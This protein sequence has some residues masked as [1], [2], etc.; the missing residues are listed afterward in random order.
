[1]VSVEDF[2]HLVS[3]VYTAAAAPDYWEQ[4]LHDVHQCLGGISA[5]L[6]SPSGPVWSIENSNLP[7]DAVQS[8]AEHYCHLDHVLDAVQLGP[9]GV[10]RTGS[11]LINPFRDTEFYSEWMQPNFMEDGLFVRLADGEQPTCFVVATGLRSES[12]ATPDRVRMVAAL[13]PHLQQ[14]IR[15]RHKL[16]EL[17]ETTA[18]L[19]GALEIVRHGVLIVTADRRVLTLNSAAERILR[20]ADGLTL[21]RG[22]IT[23]AGS[24]AAAELRSAVSQAV[25]EDADGVRSAHSFIC[26]R[27]SGKRPYVVHVL[28]SHRPDAE[29][30]RH[31]TALLLVIDPED[32]PE[33]AATL[34]RHLYRLTQTEAEV[35]L[36]VMRG[37]DLK[38]ISEHLS[39]SVSTVRTH[40]QHV[41]DKTDTHRQAE[42]VHFLHLIEL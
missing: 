11:E 27:P 9:V 13:V 17:V 28:P 24:H 16:T 2:S 37:V 30:A 19:T 42:L 33:P 18:E 26:A 20:T 12:F 22:R 7:A 1:M 34:L 6:C 5:A 21:S 40:L 41:Y 29:Q 23:V 36:Q 32:E 10:I 8:Y 38:Q 3:R 4:A 25:L 35:A 15:I 14:A 39:V 31:A